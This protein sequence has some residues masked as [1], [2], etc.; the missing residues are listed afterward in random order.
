MRILSLLLLF[1]TIL[2]AKSSYGRASEK[3]TNDPSEIARYLESTNCST[4]FASSEK[5]VKQTEVLSRIAI[6]QIVREL[7]LLNYEKN[8]ECHGTERR[9]HCTDTETFKAEVIFDKTVVERGD[10]VEVA[11]CKRVSN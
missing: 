5:L 6:G 10:R 1:S 2:G 11:D 7:V 4:G 8:G 3:R 9:A